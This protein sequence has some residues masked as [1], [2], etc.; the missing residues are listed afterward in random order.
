VTK[1]LLAVFLFFCAA[2]PAPAFRPYGLKAAPKTSWMSVSSPKTGNEYYM[3]LDLGGQAM[4]RTGADAASV[5][6]RGKVPQQL[7]KDFFREIENSET[8]NFQGDTANRLV[9]YSG[10]ILRISVYVNGELRR[11]EAPLKTFGEAFSYA[12]NQAKKNI[13]KLP[14]VKKF[15]GFLIAEPLTGEPLE[16]FRKKASKENEIKNT[17]TYEIQKSKPV[18]DAI[19]QP[20]RLIPLESPRD[21]KNINDFISFNRLFGLPK[22]FYLPSTRGVFKCQV[23]E[24]GK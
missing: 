16:Q 6:R 22:L 14:R 20:Y 7:A 24:A 18:F 12:F 13:A 10:E 4:I 11:F 3:E 15:Y 21:L 2:S 8:V 17:E 1:K 5:T 23:L 9:F 19:R